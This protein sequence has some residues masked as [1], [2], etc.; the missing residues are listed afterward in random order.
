[1]IEINYNS[2]FEVVIQFANSAVAIPKYDFELVFSTGNANE[3]IISKHGDKLVN[4]VESGGELK[5][6]FVDHH[7]GRG[8]MLCRERLFIPNDDFTSG[9]QCVQAVY[10]SG[11]RLIDGVGNELSM[12][13]VNAVL[14]T[15]DYNT[16]TNK[17]QI[18]GVELSEN[19]SSED[20]K[21]N[22]S[23][24]SIDE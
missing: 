13:N 16:L 11:I 4:C 1:M 8:V 3:Y 2:D 7:L 9:V 10:Q 15:A 19:V 21:L 12:T 14:P 17:P 18:N 6:L 20:I 5:G 23:F 22:E 24:V